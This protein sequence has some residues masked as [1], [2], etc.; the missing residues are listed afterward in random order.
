MLINVDSLS[1]EMCLVWTNTDTGSD[2]VDHCQHLCATDRAAPA[3]LHHLLVH[4]L[5][6]SL[7]HHL[8]PHLHTWD[9]LQ[10]HQSNRRQVCETVQGVETL[11]MDD[12]LSQS[13]SYICQKTKFQNSSLHTIEQSRRSQTM[14]ISTNLWF[15]SLYNITL[16]CSLRSKK[17]GK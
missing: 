9:Q 12:T 8:H 13:L 4:E 5:H 10:T 15:H 7:P 3:Q 17:Q 14:W 2:W 1:G 16:C 6:M 11:T